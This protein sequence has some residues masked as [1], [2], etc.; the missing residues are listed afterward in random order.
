M[1]EYLLSPV[2]GRLRLDQLCNT[3][4]FAQLDQFDAYGRSLQYDGRKYDW[5]GR[6]RG[7]NTASG[8]YDPAFDVMPGFYV[9]LQ[10]R[11]P[12]A[13]Y[14]VPR[15]INIRLTAMVFGAERWPEVRC[16]S[17]P[18][19]EDYAKTLA[20][21]ANLQAR[22]SEARNKGGA[23]GTAVVSFRFIDG[24]PRVSVH[25]AK[26]MHVLRWVDREEH[27]IAEVLKAYRYER[28][29]WTPEGVQQTKVFYYARLWTEREEVAWDPIPED[30]AKSGKWFNDVPS[31]KVVH[32]YGECPVYWAQNLPDSEREDGI[33]DF[34]GQLETVDSLNILLSSTQKGTVANVDPTLVIKEDPGKNTGVVRKGSGQAIY[35]KGGA[36]YLELAGEGI[37]VALEEV[38]ELAQMVFD[39]CGVVVGSPEDLGVKATSGAA[40]RMLYLPMLNQCDTLRTQYGELLTRVVRGMLRA[41][42]KILAT[43]AGPILTLADGQRIQEKPV[44]VLPDRVERIEPETPEGQPTVKVTKRVPGNGDHLSLSW[45]GYFK[46]SAEDV[47]AD[48]EAATAATGTLISKETG[49]RYTAHHFGVTDIQKEAVKIAEQKETDVMLEAEAFAANDVGGGK[50]GDDGEE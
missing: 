32:D 6:F 35:S 36:D 46:A 50:G 48:V 29:V 20:T 14:D 26:H 39:V 28:P 9:P 49:I 45:P 15:L 42:R 16:D 47:K 37:R 11:R 44:V 8:V 18:D 5:D 31:R 23:C 2:L 17:D 19:T 38:R 4:R 33:S 24:K 25:D 3:S 40:L 1:A 7:Y 27:R 21:E 22:M 34:D 41:A 43:P 13:R 30:L 10:L 12:C